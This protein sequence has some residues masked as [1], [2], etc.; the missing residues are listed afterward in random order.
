MLL[1]LLSYQHFLTNDMIELT[2]HTSVAHM[3]TMASASLGFTKPSALAYDTTD[4]NPGIDVIF[5][6]K[7]L[8]VQ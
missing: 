5:A 4:E 8:D 7:D 2:N 6:C 1:L 3:Q